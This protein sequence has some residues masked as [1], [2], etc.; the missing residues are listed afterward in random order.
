MLLVS[1]QANLVLF[2]LL[3]VPHPYALMAMLLGLFAQG[4]WRTIIEI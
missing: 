4:G 1:E 3:L 2:S